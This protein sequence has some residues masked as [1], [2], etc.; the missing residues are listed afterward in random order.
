MAG[1]DDRSLAAARAWGVSM[2]GL[3]GRVYGGG[4]QTQMAGTLRKL[5]FDGYA[6]RSYARSSLR[7]V[8]SRASCFSKRFMAKTRQAYA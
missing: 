3:V 6:S 1:G 5:M 8:L 7:N 2:L 4:L